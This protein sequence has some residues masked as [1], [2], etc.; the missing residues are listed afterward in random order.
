MPRRKP[1][2]WPRY[3]TDQRLA[4]G[5]TAY[6]W[7]VPSWAKKGG[8]P[9]RS[10]A[11]GNDY[12][13]AKRRCDEILNP[14]LDAWRTKA[15]TPSGESKGGVGTFDWMAALAKSSPK[16]P[17]N[18]KSRKSYDAVLRLVSSYQLKDGRKFGTLMLTSITPGTADRLFDR[19]RVKKDGSERRRT[20]IL[21]MTV[22][23]RAWFIARRDK[24]FIIPAQNPF[25]KMGLSHQPTA[26]IPVGYESLLKFVA[27][28]DGAGDWSLGTAAMVAFFWLQRESDIISRLSWQ[29]YRPK[30]APDIA[31]IWHHKTG[32][33]VD[34]P[35][36]DDDGTVLW[37]EL[38]SRLDGAP[39]L[40]TLIV[41]RD[42]PDRRSKLHL[43]WKEDY[44]RHRVAAIRRA[45]SMDPNE[46]FMG[47]RHGG[48]TEGADAEL[49][50]AQLRALSGHKTAAMIHLYAKQTMKQRRAGAR[51]R[52]DART[53]REGLPK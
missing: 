45:A 29:H 53:K 12:G 37:P 9:L 34:V 20:A 35:L 46:K 51:K 13:E 41:M 39:R 49:S 42:R 25:A 21:A 8:F 6:Y 10:E 4:G 16:W 43:P 5:A 44:F 3:M 15:D 27:A 52:L 40:G 31:R 47:L 2:G 33:L 38:M 14:Q 48:N 30:D 26:T 19:L 23:R 11:L 1:Q 24:P 22:C 32:E 17:K 7:K 50:D 28:A 36:Y 18:A